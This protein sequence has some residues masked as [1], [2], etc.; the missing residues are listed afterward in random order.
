VLK[1][2]CTTTTYCIVVDSLSLVAN[3]GTSKYFVLRKTPS[4]LFVGYEVAI[5]VQLVHVYTYVIQ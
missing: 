4:N 5:H 2:Y 3:I 1:V